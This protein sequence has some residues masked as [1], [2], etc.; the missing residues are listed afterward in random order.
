[1][2]DKSNLPFFFLG[3]NVT[4]VRENLNV[5]QILLFSTICDTKSNE[6]VIF[7][8]IKKVMKM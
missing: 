1:M 8:I 4:F 7:I 6:D 3:F 2:I 5:E